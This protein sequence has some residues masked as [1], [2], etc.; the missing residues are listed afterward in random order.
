[1]FH[2]SYDVNL[3]L[4]NRFGTQKKLDI[5]DY[6]C[7]NGILLEMIPSQRINSY[8]GYEVSPA[9]LKVAQCK[10]S[11]EKHR[12]LSFEPGKPPQLG[13]RKSA[14]LVILVGVLQYMTNEEIVFILKEAKK[15]LRDGGIIIASCVT[16]HRI[17]RWTNLYQFILPNRYL[18]RKW[19][20]QELSSAGLKVEYAREK[21]LIIGP[22]FSH[23]LVIFFDAIDKI[24]FNNR[25][26]LG[27]IGIFV[28]QLFKPLMKAEYTV[29]LDFGYT[30][31]I[32][33]QS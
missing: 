33:A 18:N 4:L 32:V 13:K 8:V 23:G 29:P 20:V 30:L 26:K 27:P 9:A 3:E 11:S 28:R 19:L 1:M 7:G 2:P 12:F 16:D 10:Y 5:I 24:L 14:D 15:V 22:L 6:G 25:G 17:Y 21:G 31:F